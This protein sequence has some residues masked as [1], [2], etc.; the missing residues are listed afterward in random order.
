[1]HRFTL[2]AGR[3]ERQRV[4]PSHVPMA[5]RQALRVP[6]GMDPEAQFLA[7]GGGTGRISAQFNVGGDHDLG[8]D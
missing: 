2:V 7:R 6:G 1:M 3:F 5:M 8:L 4:R